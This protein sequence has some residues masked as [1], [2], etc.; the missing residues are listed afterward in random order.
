M[1]E[2]T[3]S[4][5]YADLV[6]DLERYYGVAAGDLSAVVDRRLRDGLR[7]FYM[8]HDWKFLRP[9]ATLSTVAPYSTGTIE[10][11]A[12]V[13][14]LTTG[15]WPSWA[16]LGVVIVDNISYQI[17]TRDSDSQVT[18][19]DTSVTIA[20]GTTYELV[21]VYY[22]LPDSFSGELLGPLTYHP[23]LN[24]SYIPVEVVDERLLRLNRQFTDTT[25]APWKAALL[26][27][28]FDPTAGERW[29][30]TFFPLPDEVYQFTYRYRIHPDKITTTNKYPWGGMLHGE[31][32]RLA[33]LAA[34]ELDRQDGAG[35]YTQLFEQSLQRS[36]MRDNDNSPD[37]MGIITDPSEGLFEDSAAW[38][39]IDRGSPYPPYTD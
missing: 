32:I 33:V 18:L 26:P 16:A 35:H 11:A 6:A 10:V 39:R 4:I 12:G 9:R 5:A 19:E 37:S 23:G 8:A 30:I 27:K 21:Q 29:Q 36:I 17:S 28:T 7:R 34:A 13:V 3:L 15:T 14:T 1:A 25:A 24:E 22:N 31:T 38:S 2:S 20:S